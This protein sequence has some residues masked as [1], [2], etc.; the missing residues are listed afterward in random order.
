[1]TSMFERR[2]IAIILFL[3]VMVVPGSI[4]G[5]RRIKE[6]A[7]LVVVTLNRNKV[8]TDDNL[9]LKIENN[10]FKWVEFSQQYWVY[11]VYSNGSTREI[12]FPFA[13]EAAICNLVP[14]I[15]RYHPSIYIKHLEAGDYLL[16]KEFEIRSVGN[17][18]RTLEFTII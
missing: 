14:I 9:V 4:L 16:K 18:T 6:P 8:T 1:M 13:W 3:S 11:Q 12:H 15:G 7:D 17:H 10:V 5:Y 2:K